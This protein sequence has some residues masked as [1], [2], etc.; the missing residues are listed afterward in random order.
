MKHVNYNKGQGI[1]ANSGKSEGGNLELTYCTHTQ[2]EKELV[3]VSSHATL[4]AALA[5]V[6]WEGGGEITV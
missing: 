6:H 4:S 3:P 2:E 5:K 1:R